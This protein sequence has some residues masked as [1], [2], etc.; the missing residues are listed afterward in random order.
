MNEHANLKKI[1]WVLLA[2]I[3]VIFVTLSITSRGEQM[4]PESNNLEN[5][6]NSSEEKALNT[7]SEQA[8]LDD[9]AWAKKQQADYLENAKQN[10]VYVIKG[11]VVSV[12][13]STFYILVNDNPYS[14]VSGK[15]TISDSNTSSIE[16]TTCTTSG[17]DIPIKS[18]TTETISLS[19]LKNGESVLVSLDQVIFKKDGTLVAKAILVE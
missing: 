13:G 11:E 9:E 7:S 18:C 15:Q 16:R 12:S 6:P 4:N 3:V 17:G 1:F 19:D 5:T 2:C 8:Q 10:P 14:P